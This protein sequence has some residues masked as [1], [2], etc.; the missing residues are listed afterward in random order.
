MEFQD[1]PEYVLL[2]RMAIF[3]SPSDYAIAPADR[4]VQL[5]KTIAKP[6][7]YTFGF[8]KNKKKETTLFFVSSTQSCKDKL[9]F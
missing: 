9:I 7:K 6:F 4:E 8:S 1:N 3:T 2:L 5:N